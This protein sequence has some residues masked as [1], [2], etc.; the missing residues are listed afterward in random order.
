M[1]TRDIMHHLLDSIFMWWPCLKVGLVGWFMVFNT[2]FNNISDISWRS[3][4]LVEETGVP[5]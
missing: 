2:T 1:L 3:V 5:G 4:F